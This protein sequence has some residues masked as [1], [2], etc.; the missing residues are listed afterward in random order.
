[1]ST[2]TSKTSSPTSRPATVAGGSAGAAVVSIAGGAE[3]AVV[4]GTGTSA[5]GT[6]SS[7]GEGGPSTAISNVIVPARS[8]PGKATTYTP[9]SPACR[10]ARPTTPALATGAWPSNV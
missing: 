3:V 8:A 9:D 5:S 7:T 2:L 1:M 10:V 6:T 4:S